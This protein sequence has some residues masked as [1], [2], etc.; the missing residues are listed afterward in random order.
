MFRG[1]LLCTSE[2]SEVI[3]ACETK[4]NL[5][6]TLAWAFLGKVVKWSTSSRLADFTF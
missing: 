4:E 5:F 3:R 2:G 1:V 6:L